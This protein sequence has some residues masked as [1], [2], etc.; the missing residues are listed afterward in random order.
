[1]TSILLNLHIY[2]MVGFVGFGVWALTF[3][4][5]MINVSPFEKRS[6]KHFLC[7]ASALCMQLFAAMCWAIA[8][9]L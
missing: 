5:G 4:A 6:L 8:R 2:L 1:M 9:S 3:Y 7:I